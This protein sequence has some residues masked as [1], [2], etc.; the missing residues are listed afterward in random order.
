MILLDLNSVRN[1]KG[2][3]RIFVWFIMIISD[4]LLF[5]IFLIFGQSYIIYFAFILHSFFSLLVCVYTN[6]TH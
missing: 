6:H 2:V 5:H 3:C 4:V 1:R